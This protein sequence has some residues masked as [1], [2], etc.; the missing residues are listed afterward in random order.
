MKKYISRAKN[1]LALVLLYAFLFLML[2]GGITSNLV[3]MLISV[4][5]LIAGVILMFSANHCPHCGAYFR[6]L[7]WSKPDAGHCVKCGKVIEFD[8]CD[9]KN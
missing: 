3:I 9:N 7:Y 8:D 1:R 2:V 5:L 4:P 6:G